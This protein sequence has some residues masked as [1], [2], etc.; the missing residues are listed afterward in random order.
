MGW[1]VR[2]FDRRHSW[3]R[4]VL[5]DLSGVAYLVFGHPGQGPPNVRQLRCAGWR[6]SDLS[7]AQR[8]HK[9]RLR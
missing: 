9:Q 8:L 1:V 4:L 5:L 2:L 7:V 3:L 6:D